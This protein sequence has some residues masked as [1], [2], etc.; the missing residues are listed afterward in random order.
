M[1][2]VSAKEARWAEQDRIA[3]AMLTKAADMGDMCPS[4]YVLAFAC[5]VSAANGAC[6]I[7]ARLEQ[8]GLITVQRSSR[9]RK[10][11]IV[12]TGKST[13]EVINVERV[14]GR[15][16]KAKT[17]VS[18]AQRIADLADRVADGATIRAAAD[19]M[20]IGEST[21]LSYWAQIKRDL[22]PQAA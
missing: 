3:M 11:T 22:G 19:A 8:R 21:A 1:T 10:V 5:G 2:D 7:I 13:N 16:K 17:Q 14:Y 18:V 4:N 6:V 9:L 20:G 12:A 15:G